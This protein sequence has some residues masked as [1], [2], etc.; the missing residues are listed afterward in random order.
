M[1]P[2]WKRRG[3]RVLRAAA[4][5][6]GSFTLVFL[7]FTAVPDP[8]RQLAGQQADPEVIA[9]LRARFG[10]DD[11]PLIRYWNAL[12]ALSPV[13]VRTAGQWGV[14]APSLGRSFVHPRNVVSLLGE[15][16][17][18]TAV[19]ALSA[20]ALALLFGIPMGLWA[21]R[22]PGGWFDRIVV[23]GSVVGMSAPSVSYTHLTLPTICS[24]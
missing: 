6:W 17:P 18:A 5:L 9:D 24:V 23:G 20:L 2:K 12:A 15:A 13:G 21:A 7:I 11:P 22:H 4:V 10:L 3:R 19:L 1:A 14:R 8:A 16:L